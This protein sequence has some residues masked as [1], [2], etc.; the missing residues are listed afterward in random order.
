MLR[1]LYN[2]RH[3]AIS[4]PELA[5]CVLVC[6]RRSGW[7]PSEGEEIIVRGVIFELRIRDTKVRLELRLAWPCQTNLAIIL[8]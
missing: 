2:L 3:V 1:R 8:I 5:D 6:L 7:H 4:S